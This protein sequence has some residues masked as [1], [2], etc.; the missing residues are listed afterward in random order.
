MKDG[1]SLPEIEQALLSCLMQWPKQC[2]IVMDKYGVASEHFQTPA[3][4]ILFDC[5]RHIWNGGYPLDLIAFTSDL[6]QRDILPSIGGVGYLTETWVAAHAPEVTEY[7]IDLIME[8][9]GRRLIAVECGNVLKEVNSPLVES[10]E[11]IQS[12]VSRLNQIQTKP[13]DASTLMDNIESIVSEIEEG[14]EAGRTILTGISLLDKESPLSK[15][16][17]PVIAGQRK[18]GKSTL[19]L[20]IALNVA[21]NG[22]PVVIFSLEED[23]RKVTQ[24]L[25]TGISRN[26]F[27][28]LAN[29]QAKL[30]SAGTRLSQLPITI[31]D[32]CRD[33]G[34]IQAVIRE[35]HAAH[36]KGMAIVDYAQIVSV[37]TRKE[38]NREQEVAE[39]SRSMRSL[40]IEL[41]IPILV[42]IQLNDDNRARES[43]SL[44]QD[45]TAC[46]QI[47]IDDDPTSNVRHVTI[48]YQRNGPSGISFKVSFLGH[49]TRVENYANE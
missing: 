24:R 15:G 20:T 44:E 10:S 17:M 28:V 16:D 37:E 39:I 27:P 8:A 38:R 9:H 3:N 42:L 33:L 21:T 29:D 4:R 2:F 6:R 40:A 18:G 5:V 49:I 31:R 35:F 19:A 46:W 22:L 12:T 41:E 30:F 45:C 32:D 25:L 11:L 7:Y 43:R 14:K 13:A 47:S 48:P 34:K 26:P 36:G 23:R 1:F